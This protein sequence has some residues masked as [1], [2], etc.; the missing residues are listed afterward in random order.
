[1]KISIWEYDTGKHE[2]DIPLAIED[3]G[4]L[5]VLEMSPELDQM[6]EDL[7]DLGYTVEMRLLGGEYRFR[8]HS[9]PFRNPW[10]ERRPM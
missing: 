10:A 4:W 7:V 6:C 9:P 2:W 5:L 3:D 1:M 8:W